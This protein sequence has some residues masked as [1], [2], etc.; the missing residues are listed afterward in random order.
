M[1]AGSLGKDIALENV[2][3]LP[4][5]VL[6]HGLIDL[7]F[8]TAEG[9]LARN[10]AA[11]TGRISEYAGSR[12]HEIQRGATLATAPKVR[13]LQTKAFGKSDS[14][15]AAHNDLLRVLDSMPKGLRTEADA[16][17]RQRALH[18][19]GKMAKAQGNAIFSISQMNEVLD[20]AGLPRTV[21]MRM[22]LNRAQQEQTL[23]GR[24]L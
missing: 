23:F 13:G 3:H 24:S 16:L 10:I 20:K 19:L 1:A 2:R 9:I 21:D 4:S 18:E 6:V 12:L 17:S 15:P 14:A 8:S 5:E 7:P 22:W 11:R